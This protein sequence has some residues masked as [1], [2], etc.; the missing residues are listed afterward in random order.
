MLA[1]GGALDLSRLHLIAAKFAL[2]R[3][4]SAIPLQNAG[5]C[6]DNNLIEIRQ[7]LSAG[8]RRTQQRRGWVAPI[9]LFAALGAFAPAAFGTFSVSCTVP[10]T[11]EVGVNYT[12][13]SCTASGGTGPYTYALGSAA[14]TL[15]TGLSV[16]TNTGSITG[17]PAAG[18]ANNYS[19]TVTATDTSN[20]NATVT[21]TANPLTVIAAPTFSC[22]VT[23]A[24]VEQNATYSTKCTATGGTGTGYTW[25]LSAG[26]FPAG[27]TA[28]VSGAN[29]SIYT[30]SGALTGT[31]SFSYTVQLADSNSAAS[32]TP[33]VFAN[34]SVLAAPSFTCTVNALTGNS[35][36]EEVG[37][38]YGTL[39]TA[40]GG[41]GG[42]TWSI[43]LGTLPASIALVAGTTNATEKLIGTPS[44]AAGFDYTLQ[45]QDSNGVKATQRFQGNII[46]AP[47]VSCSPATITTP[48]I[49]NTVFPTLT[50]TVSGGTAPYTL[51]SI[52]GTNTGTKILPASVTLS[53]T[54]I[55]TTATTGSV[56][57][58]V[59]DPASTTYGFA[60]QVTDSASVPQ[61]AQSANYAGTVASAMTATCTP[62][63]FLEVGATYS[64]AC[65]VT[66][67]TGTF[68]WSTTGT[69]PTGL[70]PINSSLTG[71]ISSGTLAIA[72]S[73]TFQIKVTDGSTPA[74]SVLA[75]NTV[76]TGTNFG[77][78]I[79][80]GPSFTCTPETA[81][82][83]ATLAYTTT[84]TATGGSG[85]YSTWAV[86]SGTKPAYL[87]QSATSGA[88]ITFSGTPP[89]SGTVDFTIGLTDSAG[90]A[91][92]PRQING[93]VSAK[94]AFT[95]DNNSGPVSTSA[96]YT[97][98]CTVT[99]GSG[100]GS[101]NWSISAGALPT[102]VT[103]SVTTGN[104]VTFSHAAGGSAIPAGAANFT[105]QVAD[106]LNVKAT[107]A[108]ASTVTAG[109]VLTCTNNSGPGEVGIAYTTTCSVTT[110]TG[111]S[112]YNFTVT[113]TPPS[114]LTSS[115]TAT[116]ITLS[117]TP[118][119]VSAA[120]NYAVVVTDTT[121]PTAATASKSFTSTVVAT[122]AFTCTKSSS[123]LADL[124]AT[125]SNTCTVTANT[126]VG[127]YNWSISAGALPGGLTLSATTGTSVTISGTPLAAGAA[128]FTLQMADSLSSTSTSAFSGTIQRAPLFTCT[129]NNVPAEI[130]VAYTSTCTLTSGTGTSPY[131]WS[132]TG[133]GLPAGVTSTTT[134][135]SITIAGTPVGTGGSASYTVQLIDGSGG[136]ASQPF[137]GTV[138]SA[139]AFTCTNSNT[140]T[141]AGL[142]YTTTCTVTSNTGFG[143]FGWS[144]SAG[145]LPAGVTL[146]TTATSATLSGT[147]TST[148]ATSYTL[149]LTDSAAMTANKVF[150]GT[151]AA[152]AFTC[153]NYNTPLE[154][155]LAYSVT[156]T[157][158]SI[159][160]S[161]PYAWVVNGGS[162]PAGIT[163]S[164]NSNSITL[165]GPATTAGAAAFTI[166]MT[167]GG[168][169]V[170][171]RPFAG[172][173]APALAFT[174]TNNNGPTAVGAAYT[175]TCT[176][177]GGTGVGPYGWSTIG[178]GTSMPAGMTF[179]TNG[180]SSTPVTAV[181][182]AGPVTASGTANFNLLLVDT[183]G[184]SVSKNFNST[185]VPAPAF[186]CG[187]SGG[188]V[189]VGVAYSNTCTLTSGTGTSPYTF[190]IT[191]TVPTGVTSVVGATTVTFSNS[192]TLAGPYSYSVK[193]VDSL[194]GT[195]AQAFVGNVAALPV[196]TS[197]SPLPAAT[198][199]SPYVLQLTATGGV[200]AGYVW[201]VTGLPAWASFNP[202]TGVISG[203]PL[204]A[205]PSNLTILLNDGL[206]TATQV[207]AILPVNGPTGQTW[208]QLTPA[209]GAP[210]PRGGQVSAFDPATRQMLIFGGTGVGGFLNDLW[211]YNAAGNTWISLVPSGTAPAARSQASAVYDSVTANMTL[212]GGQT[213]PTTC[214]NDTWRLANANAAAGTPVWLQMSPTG[215]A[216]AARQGHGAAYDPNT[217][218]MLV[219]GG[220]S[221]TGTQFNDVWVL[222]NA[223]G[224]GG[225]PA[226]T[227]LSPTGT[228][229]TTRT[230]SS[231]VY[232]PAANKLV[233]FSGFG[234]SVADTDVWTLSNANGVTGTPAWTKTTPT[235][236]PLYARDAHTAILDTTNSRMT[237]FGGSANTTGGPTSDT[238]VLANANGAAAQ[239]WTQLAPQ[240]TI[241]APRYLHS[242][243]FDGNQMIVF[244]GTSGSTLFNDLWTLSD[245]NGLVTVTGLNPGFFTSGGTAFTL[246]ISGQGF[247]P[248]SL[249]FWN[250]VAVPTT[251]VSENQLTAAVPATNLVAAGNVAILVANPG[252]NISTVYNTIILPGSS[253]G[254]TGGGGGG[255]GGSPQGDGT[256]SSVSPTTL[257]Y[258]LPSGPVT[259]SQ[260]VTLTYSSPKPDIP[261]YSA[262]AVLSAGSGWLRISPA[263]GTMT[264]TSTS[265]PYTFQATMQVLVDPTGISSGSSYSGTVNF[266]V[267]NSISSVAVTM[268]VTDPQVSVPSVTI[269]G[270]L[271]QALSGAVAPVGGTGPYTCALVSGNLPTGVS[272]RQDCT[273]G[274]TPSAA[275]NF[276]VT[277]RATDAT[278]TKGT[279]VVNISILGITTTSL[280]PVS[281]NVAYTASVAAAGGQPPYSFTASG[282]PQG[283]SMNGSGTITGTVTTAP[284]STPLASVT[285]TDAVGLS[286]S[287][288]FK[289][290]VTAPGP[291]ALP[292]PTLSDAG[293]GVL[294]TQSLTATGGTPPY[295]WQLTGGALPNGM[296]LTATGII[297]GIPTAVGSS[298][299]TVQVK[300]SVGAT[301]SAPA[302]LNVRPAALQLTTKSPLP[303]GVVG[304]EYPS[305]ALSASGG[306]PPY[307]F[308]ISQ[309]NLP[310]GLT[311]AGGIISGTPTVA[312][313]F[314]I[315]IG[316]SDAATPAT[317]GTGGLALNIRAN[318]TDLLLSTGS[319]SFTVATG[320]TTLPAPQTLAV[321]STTVSQQIPYT[322][323]VT[324]ASPW[325]SVSGGGTTPGL[326]TVALN[327]QAAQLPAG[328][329]TA[330]VTLSCTSQSVCAGKS[331]SMQVSLSVTA[332]PPA[333]SVATAILS[334]STT[335]PAQT[336]S[337]DLILRNSGGG[338]LNVTGATCNATWCKAG[339]LPAPIQGGSSSAIA[340]S[341]DPTQLASG[342]Y[343]TT[344]DVTTSAGT[345]SVPVTF[346]VAKSATISLAPGATQLS[347]PQGQL[348]NNPGGSFQ[349]AAAG[350]VISW[351]AAVTAGA[352]WLSVTTPA[353]VSTP[354][355]AGTVRYAV[356]SGSLA[357]GTYYGTIRVDAA[358]A[359]NAP[360]DFQVVLTV[361]APSDPVRPDPQ[362]AGL[363]FLTSVGASA[364]AAQAVNVFANSATPVPYS[365]A[366]D[367]QAWLTVVASTNTASAT[368]PGQ[369]TVSVNTQGLTAGVYRGT[370]SYSMSAAAVRAV[371]VT[372]VVAPAGATVSG[373]G[374]SAT[375]Q[376]L[377]SRATGTCAPTQLI[378][379]QTGLVN[380]F[381]AT[382]A[383]AS[384]IQVRLV[385]D[386]GVFVN[387]ARV[388]VSFSSGDPQLNLVPL[389]STSGTYSGTWIPR[390][391][392]APVTID[393]RAAA[394]DL[395]ASDALLSGSVGANNGP[396]VSSGGLV[397]AFGSQ[398]GAAQAPG[399]IIAVYGANLASQAVVNTNLPLPTT[400]GGTSVLVGGIPAPLYYVSPGQIN[401]QIPFEL[402]PSKRYQV[403]V[404]SNAAL[405]FPEPIQLSPVAPG[406]AV[407][408]DGTVLAQHSSGLL[409]SQSAP[410][411]S[412]E[413]LVAYLLGLGAT[414][415]PV[416]SGT[417]SPTSPLA[418]PSVQPTLTIG[419]TQTPI[420]FIGLTPGLVGLYQMNF[421]VPLGLPNGNLPLVVTQGGVATQS[422]ILPVKN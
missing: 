98:T 271:G 280:P 2:H 227:Q 381:A 194:G 11:A 49:T 205:I 201:S 195:A 71:A 315:L 24:P 73:A 268:N 333:L 39:C 150:I 340:V 413:F 261:T 188:P 386:C 394:S 250:G 299:F 75:T 232:D 192:P 313:D 74:Q 196:I 166:Q 17:I 301:V 266:L 170:T 402:D 198:G 358:G 235:G 156:C 420:A 220:D 371:N 15:P 185:V 56:S 272:V 102:N 399:S 390:T 91:A 214:G 45:V 286:T 289:L 186:T 288:S 67:G 258:T 207:N 139:P 59:T 58:N 305:Q 326:L 345:A 187:N 365:T 81:P 115:T 23:T 421:Q 287:A 162:L 153:N 306:T 33:T 332:P 4:Q 43:S 291:L 16:G 245:S 208:T 35:L 137:S 303:S 404:N 132:I 183:A 145:A 13:A 339:T 40:V 372:L 18:T 410:G 197:V 34:N 382:V 383:R 247:V 169:V 415:V 319:M 157:A 182:L 175:T 54:A 173:V 231:A 412:G 55:P 353:G 274:G 373:S 264:Q 31:T 352:T 61:T 359:T 310:V 362:P 181:T 171:Q 322:V 178:G 223:N 302:T 248:S 44:A 109:P 368:T 12:G 405:A 238:W 90:V 77:G 360:Q 318:T 316:I 329:Y 216:P 312:G 213:G 321:K 104:S 263:T 237:I 29:N 217:N 177:T 179:T 388:T 176:V 46:A 206:K 364:P 107:Q 221:C 135:N 281:T 246:T 210:Q 366:T 20:G 379:A 249:V 298:T 172:T 337:A 278:Q 417:P 338:L 84:C 138:A 22:T 124:G 398:F 317:T 377:G 158:N 325:L 342:Y 167:D 403:V 273:V 136:L 406:I 184:A 294:Y 401:L 53:P 68:T 292:T 256:S 130:G 57:G 144:I 354:Q 384:Q 311:L 92:T 27:I 38:S 228:A 361:N 387:N 255:G 215:T 328:P 26:A 134:A 141:K 126:G 275:G 96:A 122:S 25:S 95:C 30:I 392:G 226:W 117:G 52:K 397:N 37:I 203:T 414:D 10:G 101:F 86:T 111:V 123:F 254:G 380:N 62:T 21:S 385:N 331:Q 146:T 367:G 64:V 164:T 131:A 279:G 204:S 304:N 14:A 155:G 87:T 418:R 189:E 149:L 259:G 120:A 125:Y 202:S 416:A 129:N 262:G 200:P 114:F 336:Q 320:A 82:Q 277:V 283:L 267:V 350:D 112:P 3:V 422:A 400:L 168:S 51:S 356:N 121:T 99:A 419:G 80:A 327:S 229:P 295:Q 60:I 8:P 161:A 270:T 199:G 165:T 159:G 252:N 76:L 355:G 300:D 79:V 47:S 335:P 36:P 393:T 323:T 154:V 147:P 265:A 1:S 408:G 218:R 113:G 190:S 285:V 244:G 160:A 70:S 344:V 163:S 260:T 222:S 374:T 89:A 83:E 334:M 151:I 108:F 50:C 351:N 32:T 118:S 233:L 309:G 66:G 293:I 78:N 180:T 343:R 347:L 341:A 296:S 409:V 284:A 191:G 110:G 42:Y 269:S 7:K 411:Q 290:T 225:T 63:G 240:G 251:Y 389:D 152:A 243:A 349:I 174:C 241:P 363:L 106:S 93:T 375:G 253:G 193:L 97:T 209:G 103:Q 85:T 314:A 127:P 357:V 297:N 330:S 119:A 236:G 128:S 219:F 100:V 396:L 65:S 395:P 391:P 6:E 211:S 5:F 234:S 105:V 308:A 143:P 142:N 257:S 378:Q 88:S 41:S 324:S 69:I 19:F 116:S 72:Q 346:L 348:S 212:F 28:A 94:V 148:G 282:L 376:G 307:T 239:T 369:S 9:M 230:F 133:I 370:V 407:L 242:A 140:P 276:A 224:T 48:V